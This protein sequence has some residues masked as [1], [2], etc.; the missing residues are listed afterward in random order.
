MNCSNLGKV[1]ICGS[2]SEYEDNWV[3]IKNRNIV[4]TRKIT[5]QGFICTVHINLLDVIKKE[6]GPLIAAGHIKY[7]E[8]IREGLE[9]YL[10]VLR[11]LSK[12][13]NS[14]K[15]ILKI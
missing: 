9:N 3:G 7:H 1:D 6:L 14:G 5:V 13:E 10:C 12:G 4:L 15:L 8:D 11:R 2:I